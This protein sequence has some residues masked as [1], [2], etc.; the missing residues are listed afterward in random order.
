MRCVDMLNSVY[1]KPNLYPIPQTKSKTKSEPTLALTEQNGT[2]P[3]Y[4]PIFTKRKKDDFTQKTIKS[5]QDEELKTILASIYKEFKDDK[6]APNI[7]KIVDEVKDIKEPLVLNEIKSDLRRFEDWRSLSIYEAKNIC[8]NVSELACIDNNFNERTCNVNGVVHIALKNLA[9]SLNAKII[10]KDG[11]TTIVDTNGNEPVDRAYWKDVLNNQTVRDSKLEGLKSYCQNF[12][13]NPELV[14]ALYEHYYLKNLPEE[15]QQ[16]CKK[17][18]KEFAT[19]IFLPDPHGVELAQRV[20]DEFSLW[21]KAGGDEV[22]FPLVLDIS[23]LKNRFLTQMASGRTTFSSHDLG[24][25][26]IS[27]VDFHDFVLR[28]EMM[29]LNDRYRCDNSRFINGMDTLPR[30]I[31][32]DY[33]IEQNLENAGVQDSWI[34]YAFSCRKELIAV[35]IGEGDTTKYSPEFKELLVEL[36]VPEW[37][38]NLPPKKTKD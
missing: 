2:L 17:I 4:T 22:N 20:Y 21:D 34:D 12:Y 5:L 29:H 14:S 37:A 31:A 30:I 15:T 16:I 33:D 13:K 1:F 26:D 38:F 9:E 6:F 36:G 8:V 19:R 28:H 32:R 25:I 7:R 18:E 10:D 11:T 3:Y 35:A 23:V 27:S 24:Y